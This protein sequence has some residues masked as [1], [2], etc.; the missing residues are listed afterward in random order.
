MMFNGVGSDSLIK[1]QGVTSIELTIGTMTL[2]AAFFV[3]EIEGKCSIILGRDWIHAN[4]CVSSTLHQMLLQ[5][6]GNEVEIVHANT[7]A[8]IAMVDALCFGLMT[9]LNV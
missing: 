5:W 9:L 6:I 3:T 8:C 4:Q 1:A 2:A 7:S